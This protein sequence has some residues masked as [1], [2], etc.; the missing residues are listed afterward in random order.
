[1]IG[2][3]IGI[4]KIAA[5]IALAAA[6]KTPAAVIEDIQGNPPGIQFMD[7]VEPGQVIML[8]PQDTIVLGY[9]KSCQR[10]TIT[11]ATVT[12]GT[13]IS[14]VQGG[15]VE[16]SAIPCD[17]GKMMLTAQLANASGGSAFRAPP[18]K[19]A[20]AAARPEFTLYGLS[21]VIEVKAAGTLIIERV[22]QPGERHDIALAPD[23]MTHGSFVD[24]AKSGIVLK[25]GGV[26]R[27][28]AGEQKLVFRIDPGAVAGPAP[29]AGRLV[30]LQP[31]N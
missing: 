9:L 3:S 7:Y 29:L 14:Q 12:I 25:A 24:L 1:M 18:T 17:G 31:A 20:Q 23:R 6:A 21:P 27:A 16:R 11:G 5:G 22:D 13:E 26:Y 15:R 4:L 2:P 19:N 28:S 10:E 8:G 30:R